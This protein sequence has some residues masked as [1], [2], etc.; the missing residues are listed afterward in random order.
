MRIGINGLGRIGRLAIRALQNHPTMELMH[1]ND[2]AGDAATHAHLLA[3]DSVHGRWDIDV[4]GVDDRLLI[5]GR[6]IKVTS[7]KTLEASNFSDCD[8]VL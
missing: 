8:L 5:D 6:D 1:V 3:F 7:E 4:S 2:I